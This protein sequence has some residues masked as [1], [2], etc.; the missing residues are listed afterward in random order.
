MRL[1]VSSAEVS[2]T[3]SGPSP[4]WGTHKRPPA[5]IDTMSAKQYIYISGLIDQKMFGIF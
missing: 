4:A 3:P 1:T 5:R 2:G